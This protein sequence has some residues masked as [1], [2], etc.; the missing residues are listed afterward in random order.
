MDSLDDGTAPRG[1]KLELRFLGFGKGA[2]W[3]AGPRPTWC[4]L[5]FYVAAA[6]PIRAGLALG[7]VDQSWWLAIAYATCASISSFATRIFVSRAR[8]ARVCTASLG[9][10]NLI[11]TPIAAA[12]HAP[13]GTIIHPDWHSLPVGMGAGLL[14]YNCAAELLCRLCPDLRTERR[15]RAE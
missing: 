7:N 5:V 2:L 13:F 9:M 15:R 3:L 11:L 14:A 4:S 10:V 12:H 1:W 8:L 6:G